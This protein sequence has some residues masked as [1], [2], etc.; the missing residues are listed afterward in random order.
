M[1]LSN[2]KNRARKETEKIRSGKWVRNKLL[3]E[4]E[5]AE[6]RAAAAAAEC[7]SCGVAVPM[8]RGVK[9]E[10]CE[11]KTVDNWLGEQ[12]PRRVPK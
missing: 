8:A 1:A 10:G 4:L 5:A 2:K 12:R 11:G 7:I 3:E 9:C 6:A